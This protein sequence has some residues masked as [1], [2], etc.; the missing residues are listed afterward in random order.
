[1][2]QSTRMMLFVFLASI[3]AFIL[4]SSGDQAGMRFFT[5]VMFFFIG[6][7][8]ICSAIEGKRRS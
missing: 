6:M 1:M 5:G 4:W 8:A 3:A 2:K 7:S